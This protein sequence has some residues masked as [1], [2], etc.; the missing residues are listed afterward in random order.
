MTTAPRP[1]ST[2]TP[3]PAGTHMAR[4][5]QV[6]QLGTHDEEYMGKPIKSNKLTLR[7]ELPMETKVFKE[8]EEAKPIS[9]SRDFTFSMGPKANLRKL[10]EGIIG[11]TLTDEEAYGFDVEKLAGMACLITI[12]HKTSLKTGK[13][14]DEISGASPLMK[15]QV[16]PSQVNKTKIL[17]FGSWSNEVFDSLPQFIKDKITSSDEYKSKTGT[18]T[19]EEK[20]NIV[21]L[22][23]GEATAQA[24]SKELD[25]S[26]IPF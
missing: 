4:C 14:R 23:T 18:L 13:V 1:Q 9:V 7:F 10:V 16:C 15:G 26:D 8:D 2:Y 19:D 17:T 24:I 12:K 21:A 20:A 11:T 5:Y 25:V 22:R 3:A 6:I